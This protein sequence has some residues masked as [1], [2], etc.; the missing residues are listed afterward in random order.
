MSNE[1][2][3]I[4]ESINISNPSYDYNANESGST[5]Y[6]IKFS[7]ADDK[8]FIEFQLPKD[9]FGDIFKRA[10][11]DN[12]TNAIREIYSI[13]AIR[14]LL[15]KNNFLQLNLDLSNQL[16]NEEE[17]NNEIENKP[18]KYVIEMREIENPQDLFVISDI[19]NKV[20]QQF[21][22]D[23]VSELFSVDTNS[24]NKGLNQIIGK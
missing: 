18:G 12:E 9:Q 15:K 11:I 21:T 24:L 22:I 4:D 2:V 20:G 17:F 1:I 3:N 7:D 5:F 8:N 19:V 14:N 23:E 16:L 10:I 6:K 13:T